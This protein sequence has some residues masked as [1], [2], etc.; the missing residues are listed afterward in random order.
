MAAAALPLPRLMQGSRRAGLWVLL[1]VTC[2]EVATHM[3][4]AGLLKALLTGHLATE[5]A[6]GALL[7]AGFLA[8]WARWG[9]DVAGE[10]IGLDYANDVRVALGAHAIAVA[11]R[12]GRGRFGTLAVRMTGDLAALK[13]WVSQGV[14][15][16]VAGAMALAGAVGAAALTT[17]WAGLVAAL[18]GPVLGLLMACILFIPLLRAITRLRSLRGRLSAKIGD[19]LFA[20][21]ATA[22]YGTQR[23]A[24]KGLD[25]RGR[26]LA[27]EQVH[28]ARLSALLHAPAGLCI[29]LGAAVAVGLAQAGFDPLGG[30]PGWAA[31]LFSLSLASL[32][33]A[34][35]ARALVHA[36]E[37]RVAARRLDA[38]LRE[39][40]RL[41]PLGPVGED[42]LPPG[43]GLALSV[44][45]VSIVPAG[46][47]SV[48]PRR[49]AEPLL[50]DILDA[51]PG[52]S[53]DGQ[54]AHTFWHQD[55]ARRVAY[56]GPLIPLARGRLSRILGARRP[57]DPERL[58]DVLR[59]VGLPEVWAQSDPLI[60][61]FSGHLGEAVLARLRL[62]RALMHRPRLVMVD[63]PWLSGDRVLMERLTAFAE[64]SDISLLIM[65]PDPAAGEIPEQPGLPH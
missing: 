44:D 52:V 32:S 19:L 10:R 51:G 54:A 18:A 40:A 64:D 3:L 21:P 56:A 24:L 59:L 63:D 28:L 12:A 57:A 7:G 23:S 13:D 30:A 34:Q 31:L 58:P 1:A 26:A 11:G 33:L 14:C 53:V 16:G 25:R 48:L 50:R 37:R 46:G 62:A 2:A 61:P 39:A 17:G 8:V 42:R 65:G 9:R 41:S 38:L 55:W 20:A 35:M 36:L 5:I 15:G 6:A 60:D 22:R 29:P 47:V 4:A 43:P 45:G 49:L 27:K